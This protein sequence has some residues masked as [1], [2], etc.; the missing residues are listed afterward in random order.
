MKLLLNR[1]I[2]TRPVV[3][4][5]LGLTLVA[6]CDHAIG[7][8]GKHTFTATKT[9]HG[10]SVT[11]DGKPFAEY[12]VDQANM[13]YLFPVY[14]PTGAQMTRQYPMQDVEG[15]QHDHPHHRGIWFGHEE[16]NGADTWHE[17][18]TFDHGEK[19]NDG[20]R[21][22]LATLGRIQHVKFLELAADDR[23]A[24]FI[25]ENEY[26]GPDGVKSLTEIRSITFG[27]DGA[28]RVIDIDQKF[29]AA[30]DKVTFGDRKDSGLSIRVPT[31][32]A[33]TSKKGGRIVNSEG[34][35]DG[36]TWGRRARWVDYYGPLDGKVVGVAIFNHPGSFRHPTSWHVREYGLFTAN[37]FGSLDKKDP[38][39]KHV[40]KKGE[41]L[42]LSHRF[43]LHEGDEKAAQI[44][45]A[46]E[47]YAK[48]KRDE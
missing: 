5:V 34:E 31:A 44:E 47:R 12:V 24:K 36:S 1:L 13:P 27:I 23:Q 39:G 4:L 2:N 6:M 43:V 22:R 38:N 17:R 18:A 3:N 45:A 35:R 15:E 19:T 40:L 11:V 29:I 46:F 26:L 33:L 42:S 9:E 37:P 28:T 41:T 32:I 21:K 8:D 25:T 7:A 48:T 30:Q 16:I 10:A 20:Q 14:G